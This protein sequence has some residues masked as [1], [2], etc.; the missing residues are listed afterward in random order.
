MISIDAS[1]WSIVNQTN[2]M[3]NKTSG[4]SNFRFWVKLAQQRMW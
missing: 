2:Y 1:I 3:M 4:V